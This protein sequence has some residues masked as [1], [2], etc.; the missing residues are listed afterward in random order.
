MCHTI[1]GNV[2]SAGWQV[3]L[4]DPIWHG[5]SRSGAVLVAQTAIRFLTFKSN[6]IKFKKNLTLPY[7]NAVNALWFASVSTSGSAIAEGP[8]EA[9]V[10][11]NPP[12]TKHLT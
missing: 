4:C 7:S 10:S 9:L 2:T 1:T 6:Q 11:R 12:T 5:S 3:T 8:R